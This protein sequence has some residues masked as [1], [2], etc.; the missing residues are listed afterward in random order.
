MFISAD[1]ETI[2]IFTGVHEQDLFSV[3]PVRCQVQ[4]QTLSASFGDLIYLFI[5]LPHL[6]SHGCVTVA[7]SS[8]DAAFFKNREATVSGTQLLDIRRC[9][10]LVPI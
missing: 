5:F 4:I 7:N 10:R 6:G 8:C 9:E 3:C 2:Q 1:P